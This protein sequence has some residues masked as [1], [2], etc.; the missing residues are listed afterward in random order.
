MYKGYSIS[1][2][3]NGEKGHAEYGI[4]QTFCVGRDN[5]IPIISKLH[6]FQDTKEQKLGA[7]DTT[8]PEEGR[9]HHVIPAKLLLRSTCTYKSP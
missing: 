1:N 8:T 7:P 6:A 4:K 2:V 9:Q 3:H 5:F